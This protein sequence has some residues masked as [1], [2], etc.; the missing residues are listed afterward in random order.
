VGLAQSDRDQSGDGRAHRFLCRIQRNHLVRVPAGPV[1]I[2]HPV[3]LEKDG[4]VWPPP[5]DLYRQKSK[6]ERNTSDEILQG[7]RVQFDQCAAV[8][9]G[10][11]FS[12]SGYTRR[13]LGPPPDVDPREYCLAYWS[14]KTGADRAYPRSHGT[15]PD[16]RAPGR[17]RRFCKGY[18]CEVGCGTGRVAGA[19]RPK[20]YV[21]I[22]INPTAIKRA[23]ELYK[24]HDFRVVDWDDP[25]PEA[26]TY[27]F[28]TTL[29]HLPD[30]LLPFVADKLRAHVA[31]GQRV[32][33]AESMDRRLRARSSVDRSWQRDKAD[34]VAWLSSV[35][36][37]V[38][39]KNLRAPIKTDPGFQDYLVM[40]AP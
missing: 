9:L 7:F 15:W 16:L 33:I 31:P 1:T 22:D 11:V 34:Y 39:V 30:A 29:L 36:Y 25:Y 24:N 23:R 27:L 5:R 19:L 2:Q 6:P 17:L 37:S 20:R 35:G 13:V 3:Q 14:G 4:P 18:I 26:Q 40:E 10:K 8:W 32:V 12:M 38:P 28:H 21:G